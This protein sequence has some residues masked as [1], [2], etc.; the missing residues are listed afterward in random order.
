MLAR[1]ARS[2][3]YFSV[4]DVDGFSAT[5]SLR[6]SPHRVHHALDDR[7]LADG[8]DCEGRGEAVV[9]GTLHLSK[10]VENPHGAGADL[11][12]PAA[13]APAQFTHLACGCERSSIRRLAVDRGLS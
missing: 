5:F 6:D 10:F 4:R 13:E 2:S 7:R 3:K 11:C 8:A 9:E 1:F 12:G